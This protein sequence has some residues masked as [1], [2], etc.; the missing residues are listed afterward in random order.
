MIALDEIRDTLLAECAEDDVGIWEVVRAVRQENPG[1]DSS[2]T[3]AAA[4][5]VIRSL[6]ETRIVQAG[7]LSNDERGWAFREWNV[8]PAQAVE[9]IRLKWNALGRDP[10]IGDIAF[11]A[12]KR[13]G[14]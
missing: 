10:D 5:D 12:S 4:L 9:S 1:L 8:E 3:Q 11:L 14:S 7:T 13:N 2:A 6:L